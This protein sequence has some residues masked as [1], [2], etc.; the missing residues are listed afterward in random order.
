MS[1]CIRSDGDVDG[2]MGVYKSTYG[3]GGVYGRSAQRQQLWIP[4]WHNAFSGFTLRQ[5]LVIRDIGAVDHHSLCVQLFNLQPPS[6]RVWGR[7][8]GAPS[9]FP[10]TIRTLSALKPI[11]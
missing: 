1:V 5:S 7:A 6:S 8:Y 11:V 4:T 10:F 9:L 2:S 3:K